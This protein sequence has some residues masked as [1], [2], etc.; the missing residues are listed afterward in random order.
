MRSI[1]RVVVKVLVSGVCVLFWV[2]V[3]VLQ[4]MLLVFAAVLKIALAIVKMGEH[5]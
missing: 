3:G 2:V 4:L 1:L 5:I